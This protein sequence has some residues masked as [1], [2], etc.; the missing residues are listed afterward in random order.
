[1]AEE[2]QQQRDDRAARK[3]QLN[4]QIWARVARDLNQCVH[5]A[6]F[7]LS[8]RRPEIRCVLVKGMLLAVRIPLISGPA[9][10][11]ARLFR[12]QVS[13]KGAVPKDVSQLVM[14][15]ELPRKSTYGAGI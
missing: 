2:P 1:M 13:F 11:V 7:T 14:G 8:F 4:G 6:A 12:V 9:R 3:Q 15:N 5:D 10:F